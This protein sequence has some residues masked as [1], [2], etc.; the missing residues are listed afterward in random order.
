MEIILSIKQFGDLAYHVHH[1]GKN[2]HAAALLI[3]KTLDDKIIQSLNDRLKPA[4]VSSITV[5]ELSV[6]THLSETNLRIIKCL[7]PSGAENGDI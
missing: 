6:S 2:L 3:N 1:Y 4:T 5:S 7:L